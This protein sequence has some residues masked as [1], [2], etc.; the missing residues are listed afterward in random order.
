MGSPL[1]TKLWQGKWGFPSSQ[2]AAPEVRHETVAQQI[3]GT[4]CEILV[5]C[6]CAWQH[7]LIESDCELG[8]EIVVE[9]VA[10]SVKPQIG[11]VWPIAALCLP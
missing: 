9:P 3:E 1:P 2:E 7:S 8:S 4:Q 6:E 10:A 5:H 11:R